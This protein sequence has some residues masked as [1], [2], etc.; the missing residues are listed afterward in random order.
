MARLLVTL[1]FSVTALLGPGICCC[2]SALLSRAG[3]PPAPSQAAPASPT[4]RSCCSRT[5]APVRSCCNQTT[6]HAPSNPSCPHEKGKDGPGGPC[7]CKAWKQ[8][9]EYPGVAGNAADEWSGA[10]EIVYDSWVCVDSHLVELSSIS[11]VRQSA[12]LEPPLPLS[13]RLLLFTYQTLSC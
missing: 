13:G 1:W 12:L 2:K 9:S 3:E 7:P 5:E 8:V 6:D 4:K 10:S 11:R